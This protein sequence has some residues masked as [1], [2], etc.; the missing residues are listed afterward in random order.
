MI[1]FCPCIQFA[2]F[3]WV[4]T[5]QITSML[6][7]WEFPLAMAECQAG[8]YHVKFYEILFHLVSLDISITNWE[9]GGNYHV[10][11]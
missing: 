4:H 10:M 7:T 1:T 8:K 9:V 2:F 5:K 6:N 3:F 11:P